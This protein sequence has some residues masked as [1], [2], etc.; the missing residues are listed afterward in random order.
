MSNCRAQLQRLKLRSQYGMLADLQ[1]A[2]YSP[3]A[4][5]GVLGNEISMDCFRRRGLPC[6]DGSLDCVPEPGVIRDTPPN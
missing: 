5:L 4:I 3:G 6:L 1:Y 2:W